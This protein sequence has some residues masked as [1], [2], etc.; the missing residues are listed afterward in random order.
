MRK[1]IVQLAAVAAAS[2][3]IYALAFVWHYSL[4]EWWSISQQT[5]AKIS[6]HAPLAAAAYVIAFAALFLLYVLA[7]RI[8]RGE[9]RAAVWRVVIA[10]A[11]AF[12]VI[13]LLLYPVDAADIFDNIVHGRMTALYSANPFYQSAVEFHQ[14]KFFSYAAWD[15]YPTAYGPGW[16]LLAAG[17]AK[18]AGDGVIANVLTFKLI[19]VLAYAG[20]AALIALTLR[21]HAPER[22]LYGVVLFAWNPL[23]LYITAGNGHNDAVMVLFIALGFYL[24]AARRF[25]LAAAALTLGATIK[26]IPALL[27][28]IVLIAGCKSTRGWR[29]RGVFLLITLAACALVAIGLYTPFWRGGDILG[30]KRRSDLLTTSLATLIDV[31]LAPRLG[32]AVSEFVAIRLAVVLL[33]AWIVRQSRRVWQRA[34]SLDALANAGASILLFYLLVACLWFQAW[35]AV[36]PV[37]IAALLPDGA[38][39]RGAL[40]LSLAATWKMPLFEFVLV[41]GTVLPPRDWR[42]WRITLGTLGTAWALFVY[43]FA[44]L[45]ITRRYGARVARDRQAPR[46][47]ANQDAADPAAI[48]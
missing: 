35:Y 29:A 3:A 36:W 14:D 31:T 22:A 4:I 9:Q 7:C 45:R 19:G 39:T 24:L 6:N 2:A 5:I 18:F 37:A 12:N 42:E 30:L 38:L 26:F 16:E 47:G 8:A 48:G 20:A 32:Q 1:P 40:L 10:G 27:L 46:A 23:V 34:A 21:K 17:A 44:K 15:Y 13:L 43:Q 25:T 41:P 33:G 28:P 11:L